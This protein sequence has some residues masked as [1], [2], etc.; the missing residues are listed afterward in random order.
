[1]SSQ[2]LD[3]CGLDLSASCTSALLAAAL[4]SCPILQVLLG[5]FLAVYH[6]DANHPCSNF[7]LSFAP[8]LRAELHGAGSPSG[9]TSV[10]SLGP[11]VPSSL[12]G[13]SQ[14]SMCCEGDVARLCELCSCPGNSCTHGTH[15]G[16]HQGKLHLLEQGRLLS[17]LSQICVHC[18]QLETHSTVLHCRNNL[19]AN[20]NSF[21]VTDV[22]ALLIRESASLTTLHLDSCSLTAAGAGPVLEVSPSS[23]IGLDECCSLAWRCSSSYQPGVLI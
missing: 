14:S 3:L 5:P 10:A 19:T 16:V 7:V 15:Q 18:I 4:R 23:I 20:A 6:A 8:W 2:E 11:M 13:Q 1:M 17:I 21:A 22:L 12:K 9:W